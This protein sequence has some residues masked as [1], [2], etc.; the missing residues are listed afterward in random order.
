GRWSQID[1]TA[2]DGYQ[3]GGAFVDGS[4]LVV[5]AF[6]KYDSGRDA[7]TSHISSG[8]TLATTGDV[9]GPV[10]VGTVNPGVV[11]GY[12]G[13]IPTEWQGLLGAPAFTGLMGTSI[14]SRTSSGPAFVAFDPNQIGAVSPVSATPLIYYPLEHELRRGDSQNEVYNLST[15]IAA[16]ALIAGSRT[17]MFLGNHGFGSYCYDTGARCNDPAKGDFGNHFYPYK[18]RAWFYDAADLARVKNGELASWQVQPYAVFTLPGLP[19]DGRAQA[20]TG[21]YDPTTRR[22]YFS[23][24]YGTSPIVYVF[25]VTGGSGESPPPPPPPPPPPADPCTANPLTLT[26]ES[27]PSDAEGARQIRYTAN[28]SGVTTTL[29][30]VEQIWSPQRLTVTDARGCSATRTR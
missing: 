15:D 29:T 27:W 22:F 17:V 7:R 13:P 5:S 1:A 3:L 18:W 30:K 14:V 10:R 25:E 12:M 6:S 16:A 26:V 24:I 21:T 2:D 28:A 9:V 20:S 19:D 11:G 8:L 23:P 4:R